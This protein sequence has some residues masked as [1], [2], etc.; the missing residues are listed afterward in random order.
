VE[1]KTASPIIL[2]FFFRGKGLGKV[3]TVIEAQAA[4]HSLMPKKREDD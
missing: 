1:K 3:P 2:L 4:F